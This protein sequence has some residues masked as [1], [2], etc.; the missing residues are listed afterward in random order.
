VT[1]VICIDEFDNILYGCSE[2]DAGKI[3]GLT[4]YLI[5]ISELPVTLCLTMTRMPSLMSEK[6]KSPSLATESEIIELGPLSRKDM[7]AMVRGL[8]GYPE[9]FEEEAMNLLFKLSG[10]HPYF[11]KLLLEHLL[12]RYHLEETGGSVTKEM[13]EQVLPDAIIDPGPSNVLSNLYEVHFDREEKNLILLLAECPDGITAE[14]LKELGASYL[15]V[16]RTLERRGYLTSSTGET[17]TYFFHLG[18]LARWLQEWEKYEEEGH[19]LEDTRER[20]SEIG[21]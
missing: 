11:V 16:A 4:D 10:G 9:A 14:K 13:L 18:F 15:K 20:L 1:F 6:Y 3:T 17:V 5:G 21:N 8:F 7:G 12:R 2:K 19:I